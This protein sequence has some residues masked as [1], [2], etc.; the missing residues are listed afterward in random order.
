MP[1]APSV[2]SLVHRPESPLSPSPSQKGMVATRA[3]VPRTPLPGE[4]EA[5][6]A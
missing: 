6:E 2:I 3:L 4:V 1:I 5:L